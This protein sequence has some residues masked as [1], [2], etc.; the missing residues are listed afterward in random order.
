MENNTSKRVLLGV[1][2][3]SGVYRMEGVEPVTEHELDT[4]FGSPS[5]AIIETHIEDRT[6]MFLPR[7]G[8]G[9]KLLPS[10]VNSP[11]N[12]HALK[13][14]QVTHLISVSAVGIMQ[15]HIKPGDMVVPDQLFDRTRGFR[16]HTFFGNGI[17]GH[18]AFAD[19]F[20]S[21]LSELLVGAARDSGAT[22]HAGGTYVCMEGPQFSTRAESRFYRRALEATVIGMT[23]LPEA[24]LA[25][26]AEMCYAM[27]AMG[28]DYDCWH[29]TEEDVAIESVLTILQRNAKLA[30]AT[31]HNL[32]VRLPAE[33]SCPCLHAAQDAIITAPDAITQEVRERLRVLY[34]QY[35]D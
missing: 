13:Q 9:H 7:H 34:G 25:R 15:E 5:D 14:L 18:V 1:L 2:G 27:L 33:S 20:C 28:T 16:P 30:S 21:E 6:V 8:R 35:L 29:E 31:V 19:P 4:P 17:V 23:A 12:I 24:K 32:A 22:V 3:G 11:A 26:E 10:E